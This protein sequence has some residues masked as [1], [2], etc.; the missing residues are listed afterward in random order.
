MAG[1]P[2]SVAAARSESPKRAAK[3]HQQRA[4]QPISLLA[5]AEAQAAEGPLANVD[6]LAMAATTF[7]DGLL[8]EEQRAS[9]STT[10][11]MSADASASPTVRSG[12]GVPGHG[13][14]KQRGRRFR[15]R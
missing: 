3:G 13:G 10:P 5:K 6:G 11:S 12:H 1:K 8:S 14:R 7:G 4:V 9:R 15:R 2:R